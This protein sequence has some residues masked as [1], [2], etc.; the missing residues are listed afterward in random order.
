MNDVQAA[1]EQLL[2]MHLEEDC[3]YCDD[4]S[5]LAVTVA[6]A[7]LDAQEREARLREALEPLEA[8][9]THILG[10]VKDRR[11]PSSDGISDG[12]AIIA[13]ARA[14]LSST[15]PTTKAASDG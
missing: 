2:N 12:E 15:Q 5:C 10:I 13:L 11:I 4:E 8:W 3:V 9:A 14:A 6:Q 1:A 7:A